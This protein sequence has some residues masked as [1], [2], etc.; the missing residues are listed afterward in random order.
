MRKLSLIL[1][2]LFFA[3]YLMAQD[4]AGKHQYVGVAKCKTCHKTEKQGAQL[5]KWEASE[6][7]KAYKTLMSEEAVKI[8][9]EKGIAKAPHE[10]S[11]CLKCH[12]AG[13][14]VDTSLKADSF[15]KED[16]VQC[17]SCHGAGADYRKKTI[18]KSREQSIKNG[19]AA[20]AVDDGSAEKMCKTCHNQESPTFKSFNFKE[21][22]E[23]IAHPVP[24]GGGG[25]E[26]EGE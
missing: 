23:K 4:S 25:D 7:A 6:H 21:M 13:Y 11:E 20:I 15:V 10:A 9:K 24:E 22:W 3:V 8:A 18:M 17:E 14:S 12:V 16:G 5:A 1:L 2:T 19:M 26:S